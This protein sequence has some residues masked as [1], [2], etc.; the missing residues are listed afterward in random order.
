MR[1]VEPAVRVRRLDV[2]LQ[3]PAPALRDADRRPH[4]VGPEPGRER[5]RV[6]Q[7]VEALPRREQR[8]LQGVGAVGVRPRQDDGGA[9]TRRQLGLDEL[10]ERRAVAAQRRGDEPRAS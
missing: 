10:A 9:E 7:L 6:A 4:D 3:H 2:Q 5:D 8:F 1:A